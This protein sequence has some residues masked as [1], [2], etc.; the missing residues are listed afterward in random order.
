MLMLALDS[1]TENEKT[2]GRKASYK[3]GAGRGKQEK[4]HRMHRGKK[5][6][7]FNVKVE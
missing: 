6:K 1:F 4:E 7:V 2:L 5:N 3:A